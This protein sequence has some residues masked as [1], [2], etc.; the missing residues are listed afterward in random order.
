MKKSPFLLAV[1]AIVSISGISTAH[2]QDYP[3]RPVRL[4]VGLGPG[5]GSDTVARIMTTKLTDMLGQ[6]FVVDNRPS[7]GGAIAGQIVA[8]AVPDGYTLLQMSPTH[9]V[10]P[11]MRSNAGYDPIRDFA[12]IILT[13]YTP[14]VLSVRTSVP[15]LNVKELIALAK[16][17]R[18]IY[19]SS[20][21][22]G[23]SHL[24]AELFTHM[25]GISMTHVPYKSGAQANSALIA[26]EV[27]VSFT[28]IG[29]LVGHIKSGR[30]RALA[31]TSL[32][33]T[34]VTPDIPT[35]AESGVPGYEVTGWYGLS[36]TAKTPRAVIDRLNSVVN[37]ALPELKERYAGIGTEIAGGS[38]SEFTA[39][40][41]ME[42]DKWARVVKIS[43][44]KAE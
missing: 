38:V 9:V 21:M 27:H 6:T 18:L 11:S 41:K 36:A 42:F 32:K 1:S 4:L 29:G 23:S 19:A 16:T 10:T 30:V 28:A 25:A 33:R 35:I 2:A 43:G 14:Y 7:A 39:Y 17:Q 20:G 12:P 37:R 34:A 5:G 40:I 15:S 8:H 22:G 3:N 31:M 13:V 24:T 44:A 26:G